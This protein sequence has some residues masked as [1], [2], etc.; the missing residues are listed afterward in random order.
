MVTGPR[1]QPIR[2]PFGRLSKHRQPLGGDPDR[3]AARRKVQLLK[4]MRQTQAQTWSQSFTLRVCAALKA[5]GAGLMKSGVNQ[6][7]HARSL[8][9]VTF[10]PG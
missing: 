5:G 9:M 10:R 8:A 6:K 2:Q 1:C 3:H 7:A 4:V